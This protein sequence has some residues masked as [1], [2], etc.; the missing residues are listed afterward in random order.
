[1]RDLPRHP[2]DGSTLPKVNLLN[3]IGPRATEK[4]IFERLINRINRAMAGWKSN[5][6]IIHDEGKDYTALVRRVGVYNPI[7]SQYGTWEDGS[8]VKNIPTSH[9]Q[10]FR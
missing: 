8:P 5:A 1:M 2:Q 7:Q 3:A 10:R 4:L 6:L 9:C